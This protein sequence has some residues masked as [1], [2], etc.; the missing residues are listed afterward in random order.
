MY[1]ERLWLKIIVRNVLMCTL[2]SP[3]DTIIRMVHFSAL[4]FLI[5]CLWYIP[6][7]VP[8]V[9]LVNLFHGE[10]CLCCFNRSK[11]IHLVIFISFRLYGF[12]IHSLAYQIQLQAAANYKAPTQHRGVNYNR[13]SIQNV[14][15]KS[16]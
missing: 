12:K 10:L 6:S 2:Q 8:N 1:P 15:K 11:L 9:Q 3:P 5:C 7:T 14:Q 13:S 16:E 4:D